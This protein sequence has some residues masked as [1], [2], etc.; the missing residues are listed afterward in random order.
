MMKRLLT[1]LL[2][3]L[4]LTPH[5]SA[6]E[7]TYNGVNYAVIDEETKTCQV[8][9]NTRNAIKESIQ[10]PATVEYLGTRYT[11]TGIIDS[12]FMGRRELKEVEL[13]ATLESIGDF[14][15]WYTPIRDLRLP[16]SV[17]AIGGAAFGQCFCL[18]S[19]DIPASV[20]SMANTAFVDCSSLTNINIHKEN[21]AYS[22]VNG[23]VYDKNRTTL[24]ICPCGKKEI[25]ILPTVSTIV[26]EAVR[27]WNLQQI[28]IPASV[29]T[30]EPYAINCNT[31]TDINVDIENLS[32]SSVDGI[33]YDRTQTALIRFPQGRDAIEIPNS[34]NTICDY[35][36]FNSQ[37]L[38]NIE[39]PNSVK[40]IGDKAFSSCTGL[41]SVKIADSV[42]SIGKRSFSYCHKLQ[43]VEL[44]NSLLE[45]PEDAFY[46]CTNLTNLV[47][48][49]SVNSIGMD[50]FA[51]CDALTDIVI[52]ASVTNI[53]VFAFDKCTS[54]K[55]VSCEGALPPSGEGYYF[56]DSIYSVASLNVPRESLD[57]YRNDVEWGR[58]TN[59]NGVADIKE[60]EEIGNVD[61]SIY[62][63]SGIRASKPLKPGI[64][65]GNG[66]KVLVK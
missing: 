30:I 25:E 18:E 17:V 23:V 54:L 2:T 45:I 57:L 59:I 10:I 20:T 38:T 51:W 35:A 49:V 26:A 42:T 21:P 60:I 36:F 33:L 41:L 4:T 9:W 6:Q 29:N 47:I 52:P 22:S 28:Y 5:V 56:D 40:I 31:L 66:R 27:C 65:V 11:V 15:F 58:F 46:K 3:A 55:S 63:L 53:G 62:T 13:P 19:V 37:L 14:A 44:S 48:P 16:D 7:F 64:Y 61:N 50:A 39:I 34:V 24:L 8:S 1:L 43:S 12:A 32:F